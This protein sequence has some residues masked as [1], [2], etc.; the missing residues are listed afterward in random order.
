[1]ENILHDFNEK[2]ISL[3]INCLKNFALLT[4]KY[5]HDNIMLEEKL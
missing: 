3:V 2:V 1:M 5:K 4:R